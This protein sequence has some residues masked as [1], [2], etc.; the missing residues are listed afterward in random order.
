[1]MKN[2]SLISLIALLHQSLDVLAQS[3]KLHPTHPTEAAWI[4]KIGGLLVAANSGSILYHKLI[5]Q[6]VVVKNFQETVRNL[7]TSKIVHYILMW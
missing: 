3:A 7:I 4:K 5:P 2:L 1:M 6:I